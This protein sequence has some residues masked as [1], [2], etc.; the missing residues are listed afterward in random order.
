M[1]APTRTAP[2]VIAMWSGPRNIST[3][4]M[5][6]F[7]NRPDTDVV[8]EP[9]YA[10]YLDRTGADHP[11]REETLAAQ[12][13]RLDDAID[14]MSAPNPEGQPIRFLKVIAYHLDEAASVDWCGAMRNFILIRDPERM[15][16]SYVGKFADAE[17]IAASYRNCRRVHE[18]VTRNGGTCPVV[19]AKDILTAPEAMLC[20]LCDALDIPFDRAMLS[21]PAGRRASDGVWG[22]HWYDA[23]E[24]STGF[25]PYED[26]AIELPD[27]LARQAAVSM[28]DYHWLHE[29]RLSL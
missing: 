26:K 8:D 15:V 3:T 20:A 6:A 2:T 23:V 19:D 24:T 1:S 17:P 22:P 13:K 28:D 11:Y 12:P 21:W 10:T 25:R 9:L 29:R 18:A 5:R 14:W 4:M 16:A 7:E 27:A